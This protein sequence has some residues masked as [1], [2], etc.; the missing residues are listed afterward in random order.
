M[1]KTYK[2][3]QLESIIALKWDGNDSIELRD[4]IGR[5]YWITTSNDGSN[6]LLCITI[7]SGNIYL[8]KDQYLIRSMGQFFKL[9]EEQFNKYYEEI[10]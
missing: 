3:K 10:T 1:I 9:D 6:P 7:S 2:R 4:L 8:N 5:G